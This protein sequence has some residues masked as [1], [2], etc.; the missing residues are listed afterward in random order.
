MNETV[1]AT[2]IVGSV[3]VK[4]EFNV[5]VRDVGGAINVKL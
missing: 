3:D 4:G 5:D 2:L 1:D